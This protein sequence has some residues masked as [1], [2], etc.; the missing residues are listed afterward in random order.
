M[1]KLM[2]CVLC[3]VFIMSMIGYSSQSETM[4]PTE[5]MITLTLTPQYA[6]DITDEWLEANI[7]TYHQSFER[8]ADS[9]VVVKMTSEQYTNY[10]DFIRL[11]IISV[12]RTMVD[13]E[14]NNITDISFNDSFAEFQVTVK[15]D[16]LYRSDADSAYY[17]LTTYGR[18]YHYLTTYQQLTSGLEDSLEDCS[19]VITYLDADGNILEEDYSPE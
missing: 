10:I 15:T 8:Q 6:A 7:G 2:L 17:V 4:E 16:T 5:E 19:V 13:N 11:G 14:Y 9:S 3:L 18:F 1:K 12:V